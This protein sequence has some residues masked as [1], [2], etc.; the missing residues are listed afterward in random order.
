MNIWNAI[1]IGFKEIWAHKFRSALTMLGIVL[2][3]SSLVAMS[4]LVKGMENGMKEALVAIGGLEKVRVESQDIPVYQ[5]HLE[6]QAV[7]CTINDVYALQRSAPL[8]K[9]VT[10][11]MRTSGGSSWGG[12]VYITHGTRT[13]RDRVN[14]I[15]TWPNA[16]EMNQHVVEHGRMFN[17]ID[18]ENAWNVCV[19]GTSIRDQLFGTPEEMGEEI[20]P[21]GEYINISNQP[22]R[23]IGMFQRYESDQEKKLREFEKSQPKQEATGPERR[24]GWGSGRG[25][26]GNFVFGWK[27]STIFIPLNTMW[28]K[29]RSGGSGTN[30][31]PDPRLSTLNV[32]VADIDLLEP[33]L[34]QAKNVLM[35]THKGIEDFTFQT[36]ENWSEN[37]TTAIRN[38]RMSGG[39]ISAISLLVG[40]IG[41]M[42]IMLASIT[43]RIREIGI[44]KAIGATHLNVFVQII[45]ESIVI[46]VL[47][48]I[49]GM[50][51]SYGI[52]NLLTIISPTENTPI[53]TLPAMLLAFTFSACVGVLAG[54]FPAIKAAK[55]DPIQALRYE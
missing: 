35:H 38:A 22:F 13:A 3:V 18:D 30:S 46:A 24:R 34:Q 28:I 26:P 15:G 40:G 5:R 8:I 32:K 10:P 1:S 2:G 53:I 4:A 21:I 7:G 23:I 20:I 17:E 29:F 19:I 55:L 54:L 47:G 45:V 42:N 11:E 27:N 50:V 52:V 43:E 31:F 48:G 6:D 14:L 25:G 51:A 39:F 41:I 9:L 37:I 49:A 12:P 36:Q 33:A 44:R 16:L